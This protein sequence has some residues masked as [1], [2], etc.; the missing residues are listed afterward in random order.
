MK[1][2]FIGIGGIGV[3][4]LAKYYLAKGQEISGC[5]LVASEITD[6]LRKM[7]AR[8]RIGTPDPSC[9]SPDTDMV[10]HSPA[11][12]KDNLEIRNLKLEIPVLSYPQALGDLTRKHFTITVS[13][14]HG[15]STTTAMIGLLLEKA[16]LDPTVIVGTKIKEFGDS[17]C[18][19]GKSKYLVIEADEHFS[20][21][22]NYS[23]TIAVVTNIERD[24]LDFYKNLGNIKK[25]FKKYISFLPK[26]GMLVINKDDKHAKTIVPKNRKYGVVWYST[27]QAE[28]KKLALTMQLPGTHNVS[29]AMAALAVARLLKIPDSVSFSSLS[30]YKGSWRRFEIFDLKIR[31]CKLKIVSDYGHHPTEVKVTVE[32]AREKWPFDPAQGKPEIWLVYQPHQYQRTHY[33]WKDFVRVL[34]KLPIQKLILTDIYDVAGR[35]DKAIKTKVSSEKLVKEI[36]NTKYQI[37]DTLYIPTLLKVESYLKK[38]L[39]GGEVVMVMGAGDIYNLTLRLRSGRLTER[40]L[41]RRIKP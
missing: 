18:K 34:S 41:K 20:S 38:N 8:V 1:I 25:A 3:S 29:N 32:A 22:L 6:Q 19:V 10:I 26:E 9:V 12:P 14:C 2:H 21:F 13:G 16:G 30:S 39:R 7:G 11:V 15:K 35:E 27:K 31:N 4:A 37:P 40:A 23:P 5:D 28:A 36:L 24:H 33:L 17:N